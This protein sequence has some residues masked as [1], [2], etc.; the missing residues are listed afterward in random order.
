MC[1]SSPFSTFSLKPSD[2]KQD[3]GTFRFSVFCTM[4][5]NVQLMLWLLKALLWFT[6]PTPPDSNLE[7]NSVESKVHKISRLRITYKFNRT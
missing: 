4:P 2:E 1:F 3:V 5:L 7:S 6:H